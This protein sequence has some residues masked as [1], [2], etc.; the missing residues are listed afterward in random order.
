[1]LRQD[2]KP[3]REPPPSRFAKAVFVDVHLALSRPNPEPIQDAKEFS[4]L[5]RHQVMFICEIS[6]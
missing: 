5:E 1:M 2:V 4:R 3:R 6:H